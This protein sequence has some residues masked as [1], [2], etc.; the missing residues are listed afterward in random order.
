MKKKADEIRAARQRLREEKKTRTAILREYRKM[1]RALDRADMA[2]RQALSRLD[3]IDMEI[4]VTARRLRLL[5]TG[6]P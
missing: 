1:S 2:F 4:A 5:T 6:K 3:Q